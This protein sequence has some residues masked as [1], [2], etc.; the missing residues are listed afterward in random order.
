MHLGNE[1]RL[2][3]VRARREKARS[4]RNDGSFPSVPKGAPTQKERGTS[5][6]PFGKVRFRCARRRATKSE[7][8]VGEQ[9]RDDVIQATW[10]V[11][12]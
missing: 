12:I 8:G 5:R 4:S 1:K 11:C 3:A 2:S 7:G 10:R 6:R 9:R